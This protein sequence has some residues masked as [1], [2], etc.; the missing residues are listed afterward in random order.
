MVPSSFG[1]SE[2]VFDLL[3]GRSWYVPQ[4]VANYIYELR[5]GAGPAAIEVTVTGRKKTDLLIVPL[6]ARMPAPEP[7]APVVAD[8][9]PQ[10]APRP[11]SSPAAGIQTQRMMAG[12]VVA[13]DAVAEA[14]AYLHKR[15]LGITLT[16]DNITSAALSVYIN[17]CREGR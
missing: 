13:I 17:A 6:Q 4:V 2:V 15:G 12:F 10:P 7:V 14:Q 5:L 11:A 16:A 8:P 1:P 9:P 3:D